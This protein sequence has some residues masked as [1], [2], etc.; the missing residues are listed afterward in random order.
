MKNRSLRNF[1]SNDVV[2][3]VAEMKEV[4]TKKLTT[5]NDAQKLGKIVQ[6][7]EE[8]KLTVGEIFEEMTSKYDG[9]MRRLAQ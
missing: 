5:E 2:M 3:S 7:L 8:P 4:I 6:L 1:R 9:L